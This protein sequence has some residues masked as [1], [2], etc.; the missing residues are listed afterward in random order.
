M[1]WTPFGRVKGI[2]GDKEVESSCGFAQGS[3]YISYASSVRVSLALPDPLFA[4][5]LSIDNYKRLAA[6]GSGIVRITKLFWHPE[7][8]QGDNET[9]G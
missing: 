5:R 9:P 8:F 3:S 7:F 1:K 4:R 2:K 6:R